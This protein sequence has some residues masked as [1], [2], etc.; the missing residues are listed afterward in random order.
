MALFLRLVKR[1]SIRPISLHSPETG[2]DTVA[3]PITNAFIF[4]SVGDVR[5]NFVNFSVLY[6]TNIMFYFVS[7]VVSF[8]V[9]LFLS[10]V[11]VCRTFGAIKLSLWRVKMTVTSTRRNDSNNKL[12][13]T[14]THTHTHT[15]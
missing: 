9:P 14:H 3:L 1:E 10:S 7:F 11:L 15:L 4:L 6:E 2:F 8:F 5:Y 12:T 13:H